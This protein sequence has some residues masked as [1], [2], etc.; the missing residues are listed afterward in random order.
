MQQGGGSKFYRSKPRGDKT[1]TRRV[2]STSLVREKEA[3]GGEEEGFYTISLH[4]GVWGR[5]KI[6]SRKVSDVAAKCV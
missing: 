3:K 6:S 2:R 5:L 1:K 4:L